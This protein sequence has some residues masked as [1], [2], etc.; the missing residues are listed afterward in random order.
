MSMAIKERSDD[1]RAA[2]TTET[3]KQRTLKNGNVIPLR[4]GHSLGS[5]PVR[6][7]DGHF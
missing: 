2:T 7:E 5:Q 1:Y 6:V 4:N 3:L